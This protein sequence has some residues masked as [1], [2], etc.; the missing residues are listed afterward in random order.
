VV[1]RHGKVMPRLVASLLDRILYATG[2]GEGAHLRGYTQRSAVMYLVV[3]KSGSNRGQR[4]YIRLG[5][6]GG[7]PHEFRVLRQ[8]GQESNLHPA[9][10]EHAARCPDS[11]K[12]VQIGLESTDFDIALSRVVQARPADV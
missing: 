4:T 1:A 12:V 11:S 2:Q 6:R 3:L 8:V 9:V 10:L 5:L 7:N